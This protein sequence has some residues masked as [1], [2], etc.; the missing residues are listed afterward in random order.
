MKKSL[1][2]FYY[3]FNILFII[4][5]SVLLPL[6]KYIVNNF[7]GISFEQILFSF[8]FSEGTNS[9]VIWNAAKYCFPRSFI[10]LFIFL[11]FFI[12]R[13]N[14]GYYITFSFKKVKKSFTLKV[15]PSIPIWLYTLFIFC[16]SFFILMNRLNIFEYLNNQ[17]QQSLLYENYYVAPESVKITFPQEK[18]NLIY[19]Y[20]ESMETTF[21]EVL[22]DNK[23]YN[24]IPNLSKIAEDN[25]SFASSINYGM[26]NVYCAEWTAAA[27]VAQTSGVPLTV[28]NRLFNT[29]AFSLPGITSLGDILSSE[30][31]EQYFLIGSSAEFGNRGAYFSTHGN[32]NLLDYFWARETNRIDEN[33]YVWWGYEDGKLFDFAKEMLL[34]ISKNDSPFNFTMLTTNTHFTDGYMEDSCNSM[35]N[36]VYGDVLTCSDQMISE[37]IY[38]IKNQD[39]Y[40]NTTI[41]I[42]GDHLSMQPGIRNYLI[43]KDNRKIYHSIINS[44]FNENFD[45]NRLF[46]SFDMFPTTLASLGVS[47]EGDRLGLG[48]NLYSDTL[49]LSE[50]LGL[51]YLNQ[52][53]KKS[54]SFYIKNFIK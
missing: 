1:N 11:S 16:L 54:S 20:L 48:T 44:R 36:Y 43:N 14:K 50:D 10:L 45:N 18:Q 38:W 17:L 47:I 3:L 15:F 9:D 35:Y 22:I 29:N 52:E 19:I 53:L 49:T 26:Q 40:E 7:N 46:T 23:Q 51:D 32:Y 42:V 37:F 13:R 27:L 25:I 12:L 24:L 28:D 31:Y 30:G 34:D 39:F 6:S 8:V 5:S 33:Y 21:S 4:I 2:I 41:V